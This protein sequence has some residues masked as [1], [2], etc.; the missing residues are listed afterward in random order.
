MAAH[1]AAETAH[2]IDAIMATYAPNGEVVFNGQVFD[3]LEQIRRLHLDLGFGG[4][5]TLPDLYASPIRKF[6]TG[7][8][9]VIEFR[10]RGTHEGEF[11]S[12]Q[13]TGNK[14]EMPAVAI[15]EFDD[16]ARLKFESVYVDTTPLLLQG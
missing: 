10:L 4:S 1:L 11:G 3:T 9:I 2:D 7:E 6:D 8:A 14:V 13:P 16:E 5:G 15:Y 12:I